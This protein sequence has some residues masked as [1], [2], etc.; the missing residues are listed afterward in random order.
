MRPQSRA[1]AFSLRARTRAFTLIETMITVVLV[2]ILAVLAI[3][4]LKRWIRTAY[5]SEAQDMVSN[6][7]AAEEAYRA[8]NGVYL[9]VSNGLGVGSLYPAQTPGAFKTGWGATC[10]W[11][12]A[13]WSNLSVEPKAPLEFGYAVMSETG[14]GYPTSVT[15]NGASITVPNTAPSYAIS[16]MADTNGDNTFCTVYAFSSTNQLFV[17]REG[18]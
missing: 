1:R 8:E 5:L 12:A 10:T 18:E 2:G 16:A 6:I 14:T 7:R 11:C 15:V 4:G 9:N 3:F 13:S 17:D